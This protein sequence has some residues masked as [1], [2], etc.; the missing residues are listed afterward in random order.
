MLSQRSWGAARG[1][2]VAQLD[3]SAMADGQ[4]AGLSHASKDHAYL[5][6]AQEGGARR[7]VFSSDGG[8]L[9]GPALTGARLWLRSDWDLDG[10]AWF[11]FSLD[12]RCYRNLGPTHKLG[13][14]H[15]RGDRIGL[16]TFNPEGEVGH[17]LFERFDYDAPTRTAGSLVKVWARRQHERPRLA[18]S[19]TTTAAR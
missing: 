5:G 11:S 2:V 1:R 4:V 15:Y 7:L 14:G 16:F 18:V 10:H 8:Q 6:V 3:D 9:E 12:G 19:P 17:A 13:W